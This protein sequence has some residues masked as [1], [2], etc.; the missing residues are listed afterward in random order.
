V[1][2]RAMDATDLCFAGAAEQAR[3]V[4]AGE[5]SACGSL[6]DGGPRERDSDVVR[7]LREAGAIVIGKP[8]C[9]S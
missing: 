3:L 7:A 9:P 6:S 5:V 2:A 4:A 8:T 1:F